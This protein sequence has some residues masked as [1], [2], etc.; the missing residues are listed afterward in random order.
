MAWGIRL[1]NARVRRWK[2]LVARIIVST[3]TFPLLFFDK[4]FLQLVPDHHFPV[5]RHFAQVRQQAHQEVIIV[6]VDL[7]CTVVVARGGRDVDVL[8]VLPFEIRV[9]V[10][11]ELS[12]LHRNGNSQSVIASAATSAAA[13]SV[14]QTVHIQRT[15]DQLAIVVFILRQIIYLRV[16]HCLSEDFEIRQW[17]RSQMCIYIMKNLTSVVL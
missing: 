5:F 17:R 6:V 7:C 2:V 12:P 11:P 16:A 4:H 15:N 9:F 8:D 1:E 10:A 14:V 3:D 13:L